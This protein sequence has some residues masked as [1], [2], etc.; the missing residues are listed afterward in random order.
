M[1]IEMETLSK[2]WGRCSRFENATGRTVRSPREPSK[3]CLQRRRGST[4]T[5]AG[6]GIGIGEH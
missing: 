3:S 1:R 5:S 2:T 4:Y 6:L